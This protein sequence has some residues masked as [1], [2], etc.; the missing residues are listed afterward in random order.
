VAERD[1]NNGEV[2]SG[3]MICCTTSFGNGATA[4]CRR[5][6]L[7][8][9][10]RAHGERGHE[11]SASQMTIRAR[12]A[13]PSL[14]SDQINGDDEDANKKWRIIMRILQ[15]LDLRHQFDEDEPWFDARD[16]EDMFTISS[17]A[18]LHGTSVS[19]PE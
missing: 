6:L 5:T 7:L 13:A 9:D 11:E 3:G 16:D 10:F 12:L 1:D 18:Y 8:R 17:L 14:R 2:S 19:S 15:P 4:A